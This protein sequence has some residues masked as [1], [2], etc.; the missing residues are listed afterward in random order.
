VSPSPVSIR[1]PPLSLKGGILLD[2]ECK[3]G[4]VTFLLP[5]GQR[6]AV[7]TW[8]AASWRVNG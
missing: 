7:V 1:T 2:R 4:W 5:A 6:P 3:R 8:G